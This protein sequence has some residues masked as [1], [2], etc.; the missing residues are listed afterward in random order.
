MDQ[1]VFQV[2]LDVYRHTPIEDDLP[3]TVQ[4]CVHAGAADLLHVD[5]VYDHCRELLGGLEIFG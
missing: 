2:P 3:E 1:T 5:G 4:G